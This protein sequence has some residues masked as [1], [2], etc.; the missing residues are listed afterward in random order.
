MFLLSV[1]SLV[2]S[3]HLIVRYALLIY[4]SSHSAFLC[5]HKPTLWVLVVTLFWLNL[6]LVSWLSWLGSCS[7]EAL[8]HVPIPNVENHLSFVHLIYMNKRKLG[9]IGHRATLDLIDWCSLS[10]S[11]H[12]AEVTGARWREVCRRRAGGDAGDAIGLG[13]WAGLEQEPARIR[14]R[15][16]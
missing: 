4:S 2:S 13:L 1:I 7:L 3:H 14:G 8:C 9:Q 5:E 10:Q 11:R 16:N 15:S 12:A 6:L